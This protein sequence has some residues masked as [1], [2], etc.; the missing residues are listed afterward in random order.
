MDE[1][2]LYDQQTEIGYDR[3]DVFCYDTDNSSV[4]ES[5]DGLSDDDDN[6]EKLDTSLNEETLKFR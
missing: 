3:P 4:D 6:D 5:H 2:D 1:E